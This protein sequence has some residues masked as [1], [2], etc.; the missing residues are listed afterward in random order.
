MQKFKTIEE[1]QEAYDRLQGVH[2][3]LKG[4]YDAQAK[5]FSTAKGVVEE[6]TAKLEDAST[7]KPAQVIAAVGKQKYVVN[8]GVNGKT[9]QQVAEDGKLL[10]SLVKAESGALTAIK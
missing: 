3:E 1:A 4:K 9:K 2:T 5:D 8:F 10:Q 6:L 7:G